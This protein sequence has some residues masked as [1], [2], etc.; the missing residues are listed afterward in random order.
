M[1]HDKHE[2]DGK[3]HY[4]SYRCA[5]TTGIKRNKRSKEMKT[6]I[7]ILAIVMVIMMVVSSVT[8]FSTTYQIRKLRTELH[9]LTETVRQQLPARPEK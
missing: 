7:I 2:Y 6:E 4:E 1:H 9:Q 3:P 8:F 5:T